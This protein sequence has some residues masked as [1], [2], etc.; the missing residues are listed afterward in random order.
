MTAVELAAPLS[1]QD[2]L[3]ATLWVEGRSL[4]LLGRVAIGCVV[5]NRMVRRQQTA[6]QVCLAR[7]QF[8]GW[9]RS[10]GSANYDALV[11][12]LEDLANTTDPLWREC[13]WIA[14][15]ILIGACRDVTK[16]A[17][18]YVT[19]R[20][21]SSPDKPAWINAMTCTGVVEAHTFYRSGGTSA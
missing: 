20:L 4:N 19:T 18:H 11:Y 8:S 7:L 5:R 10:G 12:L 13:Q 6:K 1:D 14:Q 21:L 17:D 16:G 3:A 9:W 15:G 2:V